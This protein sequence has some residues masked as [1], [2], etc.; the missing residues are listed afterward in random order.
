MAVSFPFPVPNDSPFG[1]YNIPFGIY[2]ASGQTPRAATTVGNFVLDLDTLLQHG[3][4]KD[5]QLT[6]SLDGVFLKPYLND[7]AALPLPDRQAVRNAIITHLTSVDSPI[8]KEESLQRKGLIPIKSVKMH[9]PMHLTDYTDFYS[10]LVHADKA[11]R[12]MNIPVPPAF[13][14]YPMAYNGR[15]SSVAVS[16]TE[17]I[18]PKGFFPRQHGDKHVEYQISRELDFEVEMGCFISTPVAHGDVVTAGEAWKH[19][20][21]YVLLNDWSARD[22]QK[23]EMHPFG[24]LHSKSFLTSI[25]P[26]VITPDALRGSIARPVESNKSEL[27]SHLRSDPDNHAGYDIEFSVTLS[28]KKSY[29]VKIVQTHLTDAHWDSLQMIAYQSSAGCGLNTGDLLGS[30]TTSSPTPESRDPNSPSGCGC[31]FEA[32]ACKEPLPSVAN[33]KVNWLEDGDLLTM[34]GWFTTPDGKR[35][36]FGPCSGLVTPPREPQA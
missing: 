20:F 18:R 17:V 25:S 2:S 29:P 16:G 28:R 36:G 23:Y 4:F 19:V 27:S 22:I 34:E 14:E 1:I 7:F 35:A 15:V 32:N 24:P 30:G 5:S 12:A 31:L 10:S 3:I 9:L 33:E 11:G 21:G 8:F 13:W 26:W 6:Q